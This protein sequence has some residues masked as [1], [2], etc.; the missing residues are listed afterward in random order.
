M[1]RN[2]RIRMLLE[3]G[4]RVSKPLREIAGGSTRAAQALK[5]TRDRLK[6]VERA[7]ASIAGFRQLKTGLKTTS[8]DLQA[9][10]GRVAALARKMA[11]AGAPTKKLAADFTRAKRD[12]SALRTTFEQQSI[13]LQKIRDRMA[14][15]GVSTSGLAGHER[16]LRQ[17]AART[18]AELS[19]QE[20]RLRASADR[21]KAAGAI[22]SARCRAPRPASPPAAAPRSAPASPSARRSSPWRARRSTSKMSWPTSARS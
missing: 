16:R 3:A 13:E 15:A 8:A 1:D 21:A 17:E 18:N 11:E 20:R 4:D 22:S 2:L 6:E 5:A 19:Q 14:A 9:A 10:E 12:A 7:Q